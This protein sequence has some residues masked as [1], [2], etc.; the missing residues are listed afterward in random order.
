MHPGHPTAW[1]VDQLASAILHNGTWLLRLARAGF[2][3]HPGDLV[4]PSARD[5]PEARDYT[6]PQTA[7][8]QGE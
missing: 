5:A 6:E 3:P 8:A 1:S 7:A 2:L 4:P